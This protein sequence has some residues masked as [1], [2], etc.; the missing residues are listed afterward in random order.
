MRIVMEKSG[1]KIDVPE[2]EVTNFLRL[3]YLKTGATLPDAPDIDKV[4]L[5]P[6][7][8]VVAE[9]VADLVEAEVALSEAEKANEK[10]RAGK[11]DESEPVVVRE[12]KGVSNA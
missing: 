4:E 9:A 1:I 8:E 5:T 2:H 6:E 3:G 12:S 11:T 10:A 7:E